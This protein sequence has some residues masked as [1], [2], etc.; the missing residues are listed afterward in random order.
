MINSVKCFKAEIIEVDNFM[1]H[2]CI[3][4]NDDN[5]KDMKVFDGAVPDIPN[6]MLYIFS[7]FIQNNPTESLNYY[8]IA[9]SDAVEVKSLSYPVSSILY[10][11][12]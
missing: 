10:I 3:L 8:F 7:K 5:L 6:S 9:G 2:T 12:T 1:F 11:C 4:K